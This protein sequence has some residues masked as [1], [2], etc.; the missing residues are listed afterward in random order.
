MNNA[1]QSEASIEPSAMLNRRKPGSKLGGYFHDLRRDIFRDRMLYYLLIPFLIWFLVF[2]YFPMWGIQIAFKDFSLFKGIGDSKWIGFEYFSE[3][4]GSEY[5]LR[6][7]K[8]TVIISLYGLI[9]CFPAQII[10]AIMISEVTRDKFKKVVQTLT[11]LPHFVSVVV[12]AGIVTTF[13]SP[14]SGLINLILVKLGFEEIYFLTNP[15][16]FRGIYTIMNLWKETGFAS[17][18]FIAAIAGID[19]QL[20]EAAKMDGANKFKQI[21]H[22]TLPGILPTI[23]VMFILKIGSL[24]SVGYETIIL[25]YQPATYE[26]ADVISTYVYRS[27]L[28][29]GRYDFATAVGLFNSIVALVLVVAANRWSKKVTNAGL[30]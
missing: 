8:N 18:V 23:V 4:I 24:L 30:W 26:K 19:T 28:L 14:E 22:V 12:I 27:G 1:S 7:F 29:D 9:I 20:Y 10:L 13:L 16:Y 25:L 21:L 3:F 15:D 5:F 2:K 6:V 11:Y 17:I